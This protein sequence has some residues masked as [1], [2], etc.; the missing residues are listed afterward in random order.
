MRSVVALIGSGLVCLSVGALVL[1]WSFSDLA[2]GKLRCEGPGGVIIT[3]AGT[4]YAVNAKAGPQYPPIQQVWN[5]ETY[6]ETDIDRL[7]VRGLT[8][9][10]W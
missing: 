9:C 7:I 5:R 6:P 2:R 3:V 8:L 4:D 1:S 10:D